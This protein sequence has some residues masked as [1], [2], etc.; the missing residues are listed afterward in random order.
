MP[1]TISKSQFK[2]KVLEFLRFVEKNKEPLIITHEGK[3]V[4]QVVPY[5]KDINKLI[6]SL[7]GSV[8]NFKQPTMPVGAED[9]EELK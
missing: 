8:V 3:P 2:P 4:V 5:T 7:R 1:L 9:W 6:E